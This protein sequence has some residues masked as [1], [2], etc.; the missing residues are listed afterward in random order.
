MF[1]AFPTIIKVLLSPRHGRMQPHSHATFVDGAC[2]VAGH[3]SLDHSSTRE[4]QSIGLQT[5][6]S[7]CRST[8]E[9]I[10]PDG[11]TKSPQGIG[12]NDF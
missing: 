2:T 1:L 10:E 11:H 5:F 8:V 6:I 7:K 3:M 4:T 9:N 12:E